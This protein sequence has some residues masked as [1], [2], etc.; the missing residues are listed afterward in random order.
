MTDLLKDPDLVRLLSEVSALSG[1]TASAAVRRALEE[2]LA[3]L[4][5]NQTGGDEIEE[6]AR[7]NA[8]PISGADSAGGFPAGGDYGNI[9]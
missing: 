2:R 6:V 7:R 1:E 5:T 8:G 3:R 9:S 4:R